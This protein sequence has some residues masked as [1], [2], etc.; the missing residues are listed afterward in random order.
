ME[1]K[2]NEAKREK[3][4]KLQ[5]KLSKAE[6]I[7]FTDFT[8][9]TVA[10]MD[11]LRSKFFEA[12][13]VEFLVAKNTLIE[14]ALGDKKVDAVE[15]V[16]RGPTGLALG[17]R[18]PVAPVRVIADF[19][20]ANEK[21]VFKGGLLEGEF[22]DKV[23]VDRLKDLPPVEQLRAMVVG[24]IASPLSGFVGVLNETLRSFV[25]VLDAIIEKKK[26]EEG[27]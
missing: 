4:A 2:V 9:L 8:G 22:Y 11:E 5:E 6:S 18:D 12:G 24:A 17:Y 20:K 7:Y 25:G 15:E 19:A 13:D 21:P 3:V 27:A 10:K 26:A 14:I 16:L 1:T 23:Q